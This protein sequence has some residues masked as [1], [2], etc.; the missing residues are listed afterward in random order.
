MTP[1][2]I[3]NELKKALR[4]QESPEGFADRVLARV[5]E[6]K[7]APRKAMS[8]PWSRI[9]SPPLVRWT[10]FAAISA[11]LVGGVRFAEV[12]HAKAVRERAEGE[13]AK[14]QLML[15][16]RIAGSKLQLAKSKV[17]QLNTDQRDSEKE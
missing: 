16:L 2:P 1:M 11:C 17:D 15:A 13:A 8:N 7:P 14:Q 10:A 3:D 12:Q 4:R 5:A 6:Q 9:F